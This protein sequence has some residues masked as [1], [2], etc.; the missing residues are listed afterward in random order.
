M[1]K[2]SY[3][4]TSRLMRAKEE[5]RLFIY[6]IHILLILNSNLRTLSGHNN[7]L[8]FIH[9]DFQLQYITR[10]IKKITQT[11]IQNKKQNAKGVTM[12]CFPFPFS[13]VIDCQVSQWGSWSE[14]FGFGDVYR[15]RKIL[16]RPGP[17]GESCPILTEARQGT[18]PCSRKFN[19]Q[20]S[21]SI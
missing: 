7:F 3:S 14:P 6:F 17:D 20:F 10:Y 16:R 19:C 12:T 18:L 1:L 11:F 21:Y 15:R 4:L 13:V 9:G 8:I 5:N 2:G